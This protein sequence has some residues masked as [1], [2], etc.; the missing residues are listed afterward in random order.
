MSSNVLEIL[1]VRDRNKASA[2][3]LQGFVCRGSTLLRL[4]LD[5]HEVAN[6]WPISLDLSDYCGEDILSLPGR[7][8][9]DL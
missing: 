7:Q 1:L 2:Q 6:L 4:F 5:L 3:M 8:D 9:T